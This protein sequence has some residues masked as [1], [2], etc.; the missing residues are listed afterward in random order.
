MPKPASPLAL[1]PATR[2]SRPGVAQRLS[3]V[4]VRFYQR[5]ISPD[6]GW[7]SRLRRERFCAHDPTCS[8]Y[9]YE[10]IA[11]HGLRAGARL[12]A[13]RLRRCG[14]PIPEDELRP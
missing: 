2:A 1:P 13:S 8:Q 11:R 7:M 10:A 6:H 9:A 3:L 5:T 14:G 4:G 12:T